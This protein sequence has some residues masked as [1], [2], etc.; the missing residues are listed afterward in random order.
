MKPCVLKMKAFGS[1]GKETVIDFNQSAQ[2]LFLITGDTGAGKTTIFDAIVF[3]LYGQA[4]SS[5][6]KKDGILLQSH[7]ASFDETPE[8]EFTFAESAAADAPVYKIRRVPRHLRPVKRRGR[9]GKDFTEEKGFVELV[10]P[11]ASVYPEKNTDE[12]IEEIIGLTREQFMQVAMIAQGEFMELLRAKT[13]DKKEI[14]R[15]LFHTELYEKIRSILEERKK[16]KER[17]LAVIKTQ[18]RTELAHVVVTEDFEKKEEL[19]GYSGELKNGNLAC[20]ADYLL[21]LEEFCAYTRQRLDEL[22]EKWN[23]AA[24]ALD[25][26]KGEYT[27]AESLTEA[28]AKYEEAEALLAACERIRPEM[29]EKA[30][31]AEALKEA[32]EIKPVWQLYQ[33]AAQ[34]LAALEQ[35][36][37]AQEESLPYRSECQKA[38]QERFQEI[39]GQYEEDKRKLHE[40]LQKVTD[41]IQLFDRK[42][43]AEQEK[44]T[45]QDQYTALNNKKTELEQELDILREKQKQSEERIEANRDAYVD[46]AKAEAESDKVK[47][48]GERME[49]FRM[50]EKNL[51]SQN[52]RLSRKQQELVEANAEY[53]RKTARYEQLNALFLSGQAGILARELV[54]GEPCKVCGSKIHP[55]PYPFSALL[56]VPTQQE[57]T[58]AKQDSDA[59]NELRQKKALEAGGLKTIVEKEQ[60]QYMAERAQLCAQLGIQEGDHLFEAFEAYQRN[61]LEEDRRCQE[62]V[63]FLEEERKRADA[64]SDKIGKQSEKTETYRQ[65]L[66]ALKEELAGLDAALKE[67]ENHTGFADREAARLAKEQ[68]EA[69]FRLVCDAYHQKEEQKIRADR[70]LE[71]ALSLIEDYKRSLPQKQEHAQSRKSQYEQLLTQKSFADSEEWQSMTEQ[72]SKETLL[73]WQEELAQYRKKSQEAIIKKETAGSVIQD[74]PRPDM[75]RLTEAVRQYSERFDSIAHER[76]RLM[77]IADNNEKVLT[78]LKQQAEQRERTIHEHTKIDNL[79]RIIS[80]SVNKQN[81]MDLETFVQRYYLRKILAAANRRFEKMTAGQFRLLL[82]DMEEAGRGRNEGLDLMV[83]SL[84]TG[85]KRE[86]RTLS[87]GESFMA[88]LSLALGM[89]D[90][91]QE[92]S[93]A[94]HLDMMFIDE[95]F[96]SLD[97][98]SRGQAVRVLKEMAGGDRMIGIISHVTELKQEIENQLVITRN[99]TGSHADWRIN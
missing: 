14:F 92:G 56:E 51:K 17:E 8:V 84:V 38:A 82:K 39:S 48:L 25:R 85:K 12:K 67:L 89:A 78:A 42:E 83:Y 41:A 45:K 99:E 36:L 22:T 3:A 35:R 62:K 81:K 6:N 60:E 23:D 27:K 26:A 66:S 87:G 69:D 18:C 93:G 77:P 96:G 11:D 90:Q 86:V 40:L 95:G 54:D 13:D 59:W 91:I 71:K 57:V 65:E 43:N 64:L 19:S 9:T 98:H 75:E 10:L 34:E 15:K 1:Y 72:F 21:C 31:L 80:G 76:S 4:S 73:A 53:Q 28:F 5:S 79:Y 2:N 74:R 37:M 61:V 50:L 20:L 70:D 88:A 24:K 55:A 47:A 63:V 58:L 94:I 29:E 7:F 16:E 30:E 68:A 46:K 33:D 49:D 52:K 32:Y 44:Q 97:E